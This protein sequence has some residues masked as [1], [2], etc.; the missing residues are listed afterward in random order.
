MGL[1]DS[2]S[3]GMASHQ[4]K[5]KD[6][7][8]SYPIPLSCPHHQHWHS[9]VSCMVG[10]RLGKHEHQRTAERS[11]LAR[12]R[13]AWLS[14]LFRHQQYHLLWFGNLVGF[15]IQEEASFLQNSLSCLFIHEM[16]NQDSVDTARPI[17]Q[18][19]HFMR[20]LQQALSD[21][22][23]RHVVYFTRQESEIKRMYPLWDLHKCVSQEGN[24]IKTNA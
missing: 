21:G 12:A 10:I 11:H 20:N 18:T 13:E 3:H 15:Q 23:K 9:P 4:G 16:S 14:H 2:R 1:L 22:R 8:T 6:S 7:D 5:Q 19:L 17:R 24:Q